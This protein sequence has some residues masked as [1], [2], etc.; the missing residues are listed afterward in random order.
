MLPEAKLAAGFQDTPQFGERGGG[1]ADAAENPHQHR[2]VELAV[3]RRKLLRGAADDLDRN[4][5]VSRSLR[6]GHARRRVGLDGE[7]ALHVRW[8][9]L[10]RAA[11][12]ATHLEH[13]PAQI[14]EHPPP[15]LPRLLIGTALLPPLE[16]PRKARLLRPVE[17]GHLTHG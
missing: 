13:A 6:G 16:V 12:S 10:E 3:R 1:I 4:G 9:V 15:Q 7:Q 17:R 5:G 14:R 2:R 11:V 8:V